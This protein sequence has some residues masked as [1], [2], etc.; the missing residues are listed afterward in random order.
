MI[1]HFRI[2]TINKVVFR[3]I[4]NHDI[5]E[6]AKCIPSLHKEKQNMEKGIIA[7]VLLRKLCEHQKKD[8]ITIKS[9]LISLK[10]ASEIQDGCLFVPSII[11]GKKVK[12]IK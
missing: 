6:E 5:H 8:P 10:L 9:Y 3:S 12:Q 4:I 1:L 11:R 2:D 7:P